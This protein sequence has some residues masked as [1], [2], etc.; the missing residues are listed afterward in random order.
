[1]KNGLLALLV[2]PAC[3]GQL[4]DRSQ[5]WAPGQELVDGS[6]RC[7][8]GHSHPVRRGVPRF[9]ET[10]RYASNFAFE[11][12]V[13]DTTQLDGEQRRE[14]EATF[15]EKTGLEPEH[16][17][18]KLVLDAGCGMGRFTEVAARWGATVVGVDLTTAI[19]S[20]AANLAGRPNVHLAQADVFA[21]HHTPDTRAAFDR[22]PRLLK[23]GGLIA[24][25]VYST[26]LRRWSWTSDAYRLLTRHVPG[27]L[28]Y[29][30]CAIANPMYELRT[31]L[32]RRSPALAMVAGGALPTS[33]HPHPEW[34]VLDTFDWY[35]PR[36]QRK[37]SP[38]EV[39]AWFH[40]H[41]LADVRALECE[42]AVV[43]RRPGVSAVASAASRQTP[44][45]GP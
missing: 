13:H 11:W 36:Y 31:R 40:A 42:T 39:Q 19:D 25:W 34:R 3:G 27:P 38:A 14:S 44:R 4:V 8:G 10:N 32:G 7:P 29:R 16:L 17:R 12:S 30:A 24:I 26:R 43:G 23:P 2:C 20:A 18:G 37:H 45:A 5:A 21:L 35:S 1:V 22:L 9:V 41:G 6:L 33:M 28:L 15:R